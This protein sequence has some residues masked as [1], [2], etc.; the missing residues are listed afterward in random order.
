MRGQVNGKH[1]LGIGVLQLIRQNMQIGMQWHCNNN[2]F[3]YMI[4][5]FFT[6]FFYFNCV[7][8]SELVS[9]ICNVKSW[10]YLLP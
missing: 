2:S 1:T 10:D 8:V 4:S 7:P 5:V 6:I 3:E 9:N